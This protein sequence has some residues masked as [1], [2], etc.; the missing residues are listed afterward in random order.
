MKK[1]FFC[2]LLVI[3]GISYAYSELPDNFNNQ[4]NLI[5]RIEEDVNLIKNLTQNII[6]N[7]AD[8]P[9]TR[10][11]LVCSIIKKDSCAED[12]SEVLANE[13]LQK[14]IVSTDQSLDVKLLTVHKIL[15]LC[16]LLKSKVDMEL[17]KSL[18]KEVMI[19][20]DERN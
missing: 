15:N 18:E 20:K 6:G 19:F 16:F 17:V 4:K 13:F 11:D 1:Y 12:I 7:P 9:Q 2:G 3:L 10:S 14:Y 5:N 8:S